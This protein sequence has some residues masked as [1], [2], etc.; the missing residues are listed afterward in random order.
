MTFPPDVM[1]ETA[2]WLVFF[3]QDLQQEDP[4]ARIH[5]ATVGRDG[6]PRWA[7]EF[8]RWLTRDEVAQPKGDD[9]RERTDRAMRRLRKSAIREYEVL[10]RML[11]AGEATSEVTRWLNERA[12]RN[13]I[14][15][16]AGR[17]IHYTEKDTMA[18]VIGRIDFLRSVL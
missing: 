15:L 1:R 5:D 12:L 4:P 10:Y 7:S 2:H 13:A 9:S 18:L 3:G 17:T 8:L 16:P 14:P 6:T 11:V